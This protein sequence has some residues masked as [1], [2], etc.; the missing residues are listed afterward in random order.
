MRG[1]RGYRTLA[2]GLKNADAEGFPDHV[3]AVAR[4]FEGC[5]PSFAQ[6]GDIAVVPGETLPSLGIVQGAKIY[7][8]RPHGIGTVS[9]ETAMRAFRV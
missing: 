5:P 4:M 7:V 9:L 1:F 6:A 3:A 8:I 2:A